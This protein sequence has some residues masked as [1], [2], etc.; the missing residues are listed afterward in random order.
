MSYSLNNSSE[1]ISLSSTSGIITTGG[2]DLIDLTYTPVNS[3]E[4]IYNIDI[5]S[6]DPNSPTTT[7]TVVGS[8]VSEIEGDV[9]NESWTP[10]NN[11]YVFTNNVR[12]PNDC[13]LSIE[14]GTVV[15]MNGYQMLIEGSLNANGTEAD[16][17]YFENG[18]FIFR[19]NEPLSLEYW[20]VDFPLQNSYTFYHNDF[21]SNSEIS[22]DEL[23]CYGNTQN[24]SIE[25]YENMNLS[26][27]NSYG[28][29]EYYINN[30]SSYHPYENFVDSY[31][32]LY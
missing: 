19:N 27:S 14:P 18:N 4:I 5:T 13:Q 32:H 24:F 8:A 9:C 3:G 26:T 7:F 25:N 15:D 17:L 16:S 12:I 28:C 23:A 6:N 21:N 31:S 22:D 1:L 10:I 2:T 29:D 30:S 11:P 20:S